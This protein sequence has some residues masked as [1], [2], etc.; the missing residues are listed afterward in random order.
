MDEENN[1]SIDVDAES[2]LMAPIVNFDSSAD[3]QSTVSPADSPLPEP[4]S[5]SVLK[6][7]SLPEST[8]IGYEKNNTLPESVNVEN[9]TNDEL[10][11]NKLNNENIL[12]KV[13]LPD[14]VTADNQ[15]KIELPE[16]TIIQNTDNNN[17]SGAI[18]PQYS[19]T[20]SNFSIKVDAEAAYEKANQLE[21]KL[22]TLDQN[23]SSLK[24]PNGNWLKNKEKNNYEERPT[25]DPTN[26]IFENRV[27][28]FA[29]RPVWV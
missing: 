13:D 11:E 10:P 9:F 26:L 16:S 19:E 20:I 15:I 28:R 22:N 14:A 4:E 12:N 5:I 29:A 18:K 7:S 3:N 6:N 25:V 27:T 21:E 1:I 24:N 2:S 23:M 8:V 17:P